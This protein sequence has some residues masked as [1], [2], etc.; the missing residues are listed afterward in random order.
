MDETS[1]IMIE[2]PITLKW[3][4]SK[5]RIIELQKSSIKSLE[6]D[7]RPAFGNASGVQYGLIFYP[8]F[9]SENGPTDPI[10]ILNLIPGHENYIEAEY[11]IVVKSANFESIQSKIYDKKFPIF[12]WGSCL[13]LSE[14]LLNSKMNY[15]IDEKLI[16]DLE[17]VLK[18]ERKNVQKKWEIGDLGDY[19]WQR[20]DKDF[21][22]SVDGKKI[23]VHKLILASRSPVFEKMFET[24]MKESFENQVEI[25]DFSFTVVEAAVLMCYQ[26][27]T[28]SFLT[29]ID[30]M[31][32]LQFFDK[33]NI[34]TIKEKIENYLID[35]ICESNVCKFV[36]CSILSNSQKLYQKC[37][38]FL[39][40]AL[41]NKTPIS[42]LELL[43]KD[44]A[45]NLL[46]NVYCYVSKTV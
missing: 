1:K 9:C 38:D 8:W 18:I 15:F 29:M 11:K 4:I 25:I 3:I 2:C 12:G 40:N 10:I 7:L 24:K 32:L 17:G 34:E 20:T 43:D 26:K 31:K 6:S 23:E 44:L 13:C 22:I 42:D 27:S 33:Y 37:G 16:I 46:K 41:E 28:T 5:S 36:N 39:K 14:D 19:L 35:E 21:T 45:V 30:Y